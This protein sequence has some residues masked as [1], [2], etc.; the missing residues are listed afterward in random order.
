MAGFYVD[1]KRREALKISIAAANPV[2]GKAGD[3]LKAA[4][5]TFNKKIISH[6]ESQIENGV[7]YLDRDMCGDAAKRDED[8]CKASTAER[9]ATMKILSDISL[10]IRQAARIGTVTRVKKMLEAHAALAKAFETGD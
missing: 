8:R 6:L 7:T 1:Q 9:L 5:P 2:I 4:M 3:V 10:Q